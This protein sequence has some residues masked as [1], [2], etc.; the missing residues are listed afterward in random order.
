MVFIGTMFT[1]KLSEIVTSQERIKTEELR[2][3]PDLLYKL[4]KV[5]AQ[6]RV[7][8]FDEIEGLIDPS[9]DPGVVRFEDKAFSVHTSSV[10]DPCV[11]F[12]HGASFCSLM[13]AVD[14]NGQVVSLHKPIV[15]LSRS[16]LEETMER[17]GFKDSFDH[18]D[19]VKTIFITG[20]AIPL[21]TREDQ[22]E[23]VQNL[24]AILGQDVEYL[25]IGNSEQNIE[26]SNNRSVGSLAWRVI[27]RRLSALFLGRKNNLGLQMISD[28]VVI[29]AMVSVS[30]KTE[31]VIPHE[32]DGNSLVRYQKAKGF[33]EKMKARFNKKITS[34]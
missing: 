18:L 34:L 2:S 1:M 24:A 5:N 4:H 32:K 7:V 10:K 3:S 30:K 19:D 29:P 33:F 22:D 8:G 25:F 15:T 21:N 27:K 13:V 6:L 23:L 28:L 17:T 9:V 11:I 20:T 14:A 12:E 31:L 16:E 26:G